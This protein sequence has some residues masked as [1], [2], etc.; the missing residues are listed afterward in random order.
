MSKKECVTSG[1]YTYTNTHEDIV[2]IIQT[3]T[4]VFIHNT[5][6]TENLGTSRN[7]V[8]KPLNRLVNVVVV[9]KCTVPF[10]YPAR[11]VVAG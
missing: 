10:L 1:S 3:T 8:N 7:T 9:K 2:N 11:H 6:A 4:F 5:C